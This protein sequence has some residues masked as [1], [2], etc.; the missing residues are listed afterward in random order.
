MR[1]GETAVM[2]SVYGP[3][4]GKLQSQQIDKAYVEVYYRP[5]AGL[6]SVTDRLFEQI[7]RNT[8]ETAILTVLHPRTAITIQLQEMEDR[9]GLVACCVNAACLALLNSGISMK[10]LI[11]AV[12]CCV[13]A[14]TEQLVLDP[15]Q[16][17][18]AAS[19]SQL[20]F[21]FES[22]QGNTVAIYTSGQYT[23]GQYSDALKMCAQAS[24][25]IFEFYKT[26][27]RKFVNVL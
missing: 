11:G 22:V 2:S 27:V 12:H 14:E 6:S 20:T 1:T 4:E 21:V 9:A 10:F 26:A 17:Q 15:D 23:V 18:V 19:R 13:D 7:V 16:R 25:A 5:K 3:I 8:C 24:G